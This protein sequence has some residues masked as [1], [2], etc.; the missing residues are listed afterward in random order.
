MI[1]AIVSLCMFV[2]FDTGC[3][4]QTVGTNDA[5]NYGI[6][7]H[8]A[9]C[10]LVDLNSFLKF[11]VHYPEV[12]RENDIQGSVIVR[13]MVEEKGSISHIKLLRGIGAGCDEEALRVVRSMPPWQAAT[14]KGK[15]VRSVEVLPIHFKL[16]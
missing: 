4:G 9:E 14:Y 10:K 3:F 16:E 1:R 6:S 15:P 11:N 5:R 13:F 12:A 8:K 2:A 7:Y